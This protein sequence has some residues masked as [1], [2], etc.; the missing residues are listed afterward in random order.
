MLQSFLTS[1][2]DKIQ[3]FYDY[4]G[5]KFPGNESIILWLIIIACSL[6]IPHFT[7]SKQ[8]TLLSALASY[9]FC[10]P[11]AEM[12]CYTNNAMKSEK[13][14]IIFTLIVTYLYLWSEAHKYDNNIYSGLSGVLIRTPKL[15]VISLFTIA[16]FLSL[17]I[18]SSLA[19]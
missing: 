12:A 15:L 14:L 4:V 6:L 16:S 19:S 3:P 2:R 17:T 13:I 8:K 11:L 5:M 18:C 9:A 1:I 7:N 10:A